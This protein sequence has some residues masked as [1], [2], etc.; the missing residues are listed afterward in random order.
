MNSIACSSKFSVLLS[1]PRFAESRKIL[2]E[3]T[4]SVRRCYSLAPR[5]RASW[6]SRLQCSHPERWSQ[7]TAR[8]RRQR[9]ERAQSTRYVH[10]GSSGT[11]SSEGEPCR[12]D[13][14]SS[15]ECNGEETSSSMYPD[16][17]H[18]K[19][20][21]FRSL[22]QDDD[23][24]FQ[25]TASLPPKT[26][27]RLL[28]TLFEAEEKS[29]GHCS[30]RAD[31]FFRLMDNDMDGRVSRREFRLWF[32]TFFVPSILQDISSDDGRKVLDASAPASSQQSSAAATTAENAPLEVESAPTPL[33]VPY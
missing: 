23:T 22:T 1:L 6:S 16:C 5:C 2:C 12:D 33:Q 30:D 17:L 20:A 28:R 4:P 9:W 10:G 15:L 11:G 7:R 31:S 13:A 26:R 24:F 8:T 32:K 18:A 21:V 14:A 25:F 29:A 19:G 3:A 27:R